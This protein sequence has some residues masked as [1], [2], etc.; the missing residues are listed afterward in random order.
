MIAHLKAGPIALYETSSFL[1]GMGPYGFSQAFEKH[2]AAFHKSDEFKERADAAKPFFKGI[3]DFV[4][5]RPTSLENIVRI[6]CL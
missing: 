3:T 1:F 2:I 5:G 6:G 4:F